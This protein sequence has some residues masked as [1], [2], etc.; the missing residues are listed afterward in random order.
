[1]CPFCAPFLFTKS[2]LPR[3]IDVINQFDNGRNQEMKTKFAIKEVKAMEALIDNYTDLISDGRLSKQEK[4][5]LDYLDYNFKQLNKTLDVYDIDPKMFHQSGIMKKSQL[6]LSIDLSNQNKELAQKI[7]K[8]NWSS[9][10]V[11]LPILD[12]TYDQYKNLFE[13]FEPKKSENEPN[14]WDG[15]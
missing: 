1:V 9:L 4:F 12:I 8:Y 10:E 2:F 6:D 11:I 13:K 5:S 15:V 14:H 7:M 3:N